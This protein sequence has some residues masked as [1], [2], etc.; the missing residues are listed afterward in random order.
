MQVE[1]ETGF[2]QWK[3]ADERVTRKNLPRTRGQLG[4]S[5]ANTGWSRKSKDLSVREGLAGYQ[6]VGEVTAHQDNDGYLV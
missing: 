1:R 4:E 2:I 6:F 3:A 5:R